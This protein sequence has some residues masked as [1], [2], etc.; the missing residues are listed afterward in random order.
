MLRYRSILN[1]NNNSS[2]SFHGWCHRQSVAARTPQWPI[3]S[4]GTAVSTHMNSM[5]PRNSIEFNR[6]HF[7]LN[8]SSVVGEYHIPVVARISEEE[9]LMMEEAQGDATG[10]CNRRPHDSAV[11]AE[12]LQE[13]PLQKPIKCR[14]FNCWHWPG[15]QN[16]KSESTD[17]E[18]R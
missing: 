12:N 7:I 1:C 15:R 8:T 3:A 5:A 10:F 14:R 16:V 18:S 11:K 17:R 13:N 4:N 6:V 9:S 2:I